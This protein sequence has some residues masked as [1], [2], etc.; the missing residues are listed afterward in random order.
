[1]EC[2]WWPRRHPR[3]R[4]RIG[5]R[6]II[7]V[8]IVYACQIISNVTSSNLNKCCSS[9]LFLWSDG[10]KQLITIKY[11]W[12]VLYNIGICV[13]WALMVIDR[14]SLYLFAFSVL[15]FSFSNELLMLWTGKEGRVM[16]NVQVTL[17]N[18]ISTEGKWLLIVSLINIRLMLLFF[19]KL[20]NCFQKNYFWPVL[21]LHFQSLRPYVVF[22]L[23]SHIVKLPHACTWFSNIKNT[24]HLL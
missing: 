11:R 1:M 20:F 24:N 8:I 9:S 16:E 12:N 7:I 6:G 19:S 17:C 13:I 15:I 5:L 23:S 18:I 14:C 21:L 4:W 2:R 22:G 10:I 3:R